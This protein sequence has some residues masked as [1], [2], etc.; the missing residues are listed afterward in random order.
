[1][2]LSAVR[3]LLPL[4][5]AYDHVNYARYLPAY[6]LE[7]CDLPSSHPAVHHEFMKGHF[8]VQR[9]ADHGFSQVACDQAIEQTCNRDTKTKGRMVG[10]TTQKGAVSRWILSQ[11]E[12][13]AIS[14]RCEELAGKDE[15]SRG[16]KD[17]QP[18]Q[19]QRYEEDICKA[20]TV[21]EAMINPFEDSH[22]QIIHIA[23]GAVASKEVSA[24]YINAREKGDAAFI[25]NCKERLQLAHRLRR[26]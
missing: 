14:R 16:R 3:S 15:R 6:W 12:R 1:M 17:L 18:S 25:S 21:F 2:H 9:K 4:L 26:C 11:Q 24:D 19:I 20:V 13:S 5:F 10:F 23:S 7:M 8:S 22:D